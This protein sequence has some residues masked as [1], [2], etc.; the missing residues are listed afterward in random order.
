MT[1]IMVI[2]EMVFFTPIAISIQEGLLVL[3]AYHKYKMGIQHIRFPFRFND[4]RIHSDFIT[5][6]AFESTSQ[7][8]GGK[9]T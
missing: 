4:Y 1:S 5:I 7:L 2:Y 8:Q 3:F 6:T 9:C